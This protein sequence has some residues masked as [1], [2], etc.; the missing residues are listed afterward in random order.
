MASLQ[1]GATGPEVTVLQR[2]LQAHGFPPGNVDGAFGLGTEA[3]VLAFQKS[4]GLLPDGIAGQRTLAALGIP[5]GESPSPI[6]GVTVVMVSMMFPHTPIGNIKQNLPIVLD[7]LVK[8]DITGKPMVLTALATIRAETES[9]EPIPEETSRYNSSPNGHPFDLYD[10]RRDLGNT[11]PP[12][13]LLYRGRGYIQLTGRFN[14]AKYGA[15]LGMGDELTA[16]PDLACDRAIAAD[17][18][19]AFLQDKQ[20]AIEEALL[21]QELSRVRRLVNGGTHGLEQFVEA[22]KAGDKLL[23]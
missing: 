9:F 21:Y 22:Y 18:L 1:R 7:S 4:A 6:P 8:A 15:R 20:A 23:Q 14:Y 3:A 17:L 10:N 16:Q 2:A 5:P 11:G 12:D 13:G 19:V